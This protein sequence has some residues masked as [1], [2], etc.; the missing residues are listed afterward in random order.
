PLNDA[1]IAHQLLTAYD[2]RQIRLVF[3]QGF[4]LQPVA[5][6]SQMQPVLAVVFEIGEE[7]VGRLLR[8]DLRREQ[9]HDE[10]QSGKM[11]G[12]HGATSTD[13]SCVPWVETY[14]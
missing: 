1:G 8:H 14:G 9:R 4:P 10:D 7:V 2:R 5:A 11:F 13:F 12:V 3:I 6:V